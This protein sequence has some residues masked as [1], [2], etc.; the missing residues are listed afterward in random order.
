MAVRLDNGFVAASCA[1]KE[2][3]GS[4]LQ[5]NLFSH[6]VQDA[7]STNA[8]KRVHGCDIRKMRRPVLHRTTP[9]NDMVFR[10]RMEAMP[11]MFVP[12]VLLFF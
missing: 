1:K 3:N 10:S 12:R 7:L 5:N 6:S 11:A 2:T 4:F 8:F 9:L